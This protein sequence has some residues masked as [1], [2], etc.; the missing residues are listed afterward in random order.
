[1]FPLKV[2]HSTT[3]SHYH[4]TSHGRDAWMAVVVEGRAAH[5]PLTTSLRHD[6]LGTER[7]QAEA[8][9]DKETRVGARQM[10]VAWRCRWL[11]LFLCIAFPK[12]LCPSCAS[13]QHVPLSFQFPGKWF[14]RVNAL[15]SPPA[16]SFRSLSSTEPFGLTSVHELSSLPRRVI[17]V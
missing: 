15:V 13:K 17:V 2:Q 11:S 8:R 16:S 10:W 7:G 9:K 14:I 3:C 6:W 1:M 5:W 4:N 12:S